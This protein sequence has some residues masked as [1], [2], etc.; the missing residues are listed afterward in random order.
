MT[1][2][3]SKPLGEQAWERYE[4]DMHSTSSPWLSE[5][6]YQTYL[7]LETLPSRFPSTKTTWLR[8]PLLHDY[9]WRVSYWHDKQHRLSCDLF[10]PLEEASSP[11]SSSSS[12]FFSSLSAQT[13]AAR[14]DDDNEDND[15]EDGDGAGT[16]FAFNLDWLDRT[17]QRQL[18][19]H[20]S[21]TNGGLHVIVELV[22]RVSGIPLSR[23]SIKIGPQYSGADTKNISIGVSGAISLEMSSCYDLRFVTSTIPNRIGFHP[24]ILNEHLP[25]YNCV[26][27]YIRAPSSASHWKMNRPLVILPAFVPSPREVILAT[28]ADS[29]PDHLLRPCR[30]FAQVEDLQIT[31]DLFDLCISD[32][33]IVSARCVGG[34]TSHAPTPAFLGEMVT[35]GE[36]SWLTC[37]EVQLPHGATT[38]SKIRLDIVG[39]SIGPETET[40]GKGS[41]HHQKAMELCSGVLTPKCKRNQSSPTSIYDPSQ[42][43]HE[44][45]KSSSSSG[46]GGGYLSEELLMAGEM[47]LESGVYEVPLFAHPTTVVVGYRSMDEEGA[48]E[49]PEG[50]FVGRLVV[51]LSVIGDG[52]EGPI[53]HDATDLD[54]YLFP[55]VFNFDIVGV[56]LYS[57]PVPQC[58]A[59]SICDHL[60]SHLLSLDP[61]PT[62]MVHPDLGDDLGRRNV[63]DKLGVVDAISCVTACSRRI[64]SQSSGLSRTLLSPGA[65]VQPHLTFAGGV[66]QRDSNSVPLLVMSHLVHRLLQSG[67]CDAPVLS[68]IA[69][70]IDKAGGNNG[71]WSTFQAWSSSTSA[72]QFMSG[73]H[74]A[75]K[76]GAS[77]QFLIPSKD[78]FDRA[79][80]AFWCFRVLGF[81]HHVERIHG[82]PLLGPTSGA[83]SSSSLTT[84]ASMA[85]DLLHVMLGSLAPTI[86]HLVSE[87][88]VS[89]AHAKAHASDAELVNAELEKQRALCVVTVAE[90]LSSTLDCSSLLLP[91]AGDI[92]FNVASSVLAVTE[93][94]VKVPFTPLCGGAASPAAS[95][96]LARFVVFISLLIRQ[97]PSGLDLLLHPTAHV[98]TRSAVGKMSSQ[99]L[100]SERKVVTGTAA[101]RASKN[102]PGR[103]GGGGKS[104]DNS[105]AGCITD[106]I[107]ALCTFFSTGG[108]EPFREV[109]GRISG[110]ITIA[111]RELSTTI[112]RAVFARIVANPASSLS[113]SAS[114]HGGA[115]A[116]E[117]TSPLP[118]LPATA[119][120]KKGGAALTSVA[121]GS[122]SNSASSANRIST[123]ADIKELYSQHQAY[124]AK[125]VYGNV[126][127]L[128]K[129][130]PLGMRSPAVG[131]SSV[132]A[133]GRERS[134]AYHEEK[135]DP[136]TVTA[137]RSLMENGGM[138]VE[139]RNGTFTLKGD[140]A[141]IYIGERVQFLHGLLVLAVA[142]GSL[143]EI[144]CDARLGDGGAMSATRARS[145]VNVVLNS[146]VPTPAGFANE[147]HHDELLKQAL[148][149]LAQSKGPSGSNYVLLLIHLTDAFALYWRS[150][151]ALTKGM[152]SIEPFTIAAPHVVIPRLQSLDRA[153]LPIQL[154]RDVELLTQAARTLFS[155][156]PNDEALSISEVRAYS[157]A[158][159]FRALAMQQQERKG[160]LNESFLLSTGD[161][162]GISS[163]LRLRRNLI[164]AVVGLLRAGIRLG[165]FEAEAVLAH[166]ANEA[167][168]KLNSASG[169]PS[170][171]HPATHDS[172]VRRLQALSSLADVS[173]RTPTRAVSAS[174]FAGTPL[175]CLVWLL[176]D[177]ADM[178]PLEENRTDLALLCLQSNDDAKRTLTTLFSIAVD[179]PVIPADSKLPAAGAISKVLDMARQDLMGGCINVMQIMSYDLHAS[180]LALEAYFQSILD[181]CIAH[182]IPAG[183]KETF[184]PVLSALL[185]SS[186]TI[187]PTLVNST[188][189]GFAAA[190]SSLLNLLSEPA[191]M[192]ST[193]LWKMRERITRRLTA[194]R[195]FVLSRFTAALPEPPAGSDE[196]IEVA[197]RKSFSLVAAGASLQTLLHM[198]PHQV[199]KGGWGL[200]LRDRG[201]VLKELGALTPSNGSRTWSLKDDPTLLEGHHH[202][203]SHPL[204][205]QMGRGFSEEQL[206][207][208]LRNLGLGHRA[209]QA[210]MHLSMSEVFALEQLVA[211]A[212][213]AGGDGKVSFIDVEYGEDEHR[214]ARAALTYMLQSGEWETGLSLAMT[215][216]EQCARTQAK[217][218]EALQ[219]AT[220]KVTQ[221][222][223]AANNSAGQVLHELTLRI[224]RQNTLQ[225]ELSKAQEKLKQRLV[226]DEQHRPLPIFYALR[227][228]ENPWIDVDV[229]HG[230]EAFLDATNCH[231]QGFTVVKAV[232][233]DIDDLA[234]GREERKKHHRHLDTDSNDDDGKEL[235]RQLKKKKEEAKEAAAPPGIGRGMWILLRC[236]PT[237]FSRNA[238]V[239][240]ELAE[241]AT[242]KLRKRRAYRGSASS[243]SCSEDSASSS[244]SSE[245]EDD[246]D[247]DDEDESNRVK[248]PLPSACSVSLQAQLLR[249]FPSYQML[250]PISLV[251]LDQMGDET[252][253]RAMQLFQAFPSAL[254]AAADAGLGSSETVGVHAVLRKQTEETAASSNTS[255]GDEGDEYE[256]SKA[257]KANDALKRGVSQPESDWEMA[258]HSDTFYVF[259]SLDNESE[260][261][262]YLSSH[263][264]TSIVRLT[265][266]TVSA[267]SGAEAAKGH[268]VDE[269]GEHKGE[270][271]ADDVDTSDMGL[272]AWAGDRAGTIGKLHVLAPASLLFVTDAKR[273][274]AFEAGMSVIRHQL[275]ALNRLQSALSNASKLT[276]TETLQQTSHDITSN[277]SVMAAVANTVSNMI[278]SPSSICVGVHNARA[279]VSFQTLSPHFPQI[280]H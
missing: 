107:I 48:D 22:H 151:T 163:W 169:D 186:D 59:T 32:R 158:Q 165:L 45:G 103:R 115:D 138:A 198:A 29:G 73:A 102:A 276:M 177:L 243:D 247:D 206:F 172:F 197:L 201:V 205:S 130:V 157:S 12:S 28:N 128:G 52:G 168:N 246:E 49:E 23:G 11:A 16:V 223:K 145:I 50:I 125:D 88:Y 263:G 83:Y 37:S 272:L 67:V 24:T 26:L 139:F 143:S 180:P 213:A 234:G 185:K 269:A 75:K 251:E 179:L 113:A 235:E 153:Y 212:G 144:P 190:V 121:A 237:A 62:W 55:K 97:Q 60:I 105:A 191:A 202:N 209:G 44:E 236:D 38:L 110:S 136:V 219:V 225:T 76:K 98:W 256:T 31:P 278:V 258:M 218:Q 132:V 167:R 146:I 244:S 161:L 187:E 34:G 35:N 25:E 131:L 134:G 15:E 204:L 150:C 264:D 268:E 56:G 79:K 99:S 100:K 1:K 195:I 123:K 230:L 245:D 152:G 94:L 70:L 81:S 77:L 137:V 120:R 253:P 176:R 114:T 17:Q 200:D 275:Q 260:M 229:Q 65:V 124:S 71:L 173:S 109:G 43:G 47:V 224:R 78:D 68:T 41:N 2:S 232:S 216:S 181:E 5:D 248:V 196:Y 54:P 210:L 63:Y 119:R 271:D 86:N 154:A 222:S 162:S 240:Q 239:Y 262:E 166:T 101:D 84:T 182:C 126:T 30:C 164:D 149:S 61:L 160:G 140:D 257:F 188:P 66:S 183:M 6:G 20:A 72:Q 112:E 175:N 184:E 90:I 133:N 148:D 242:E 170:Q 226:H 4:I 21:S 95:E 89:V 238:E 221:A 274:T 277:A 194:V 270:Q 14:D 93:A 106:C 241:K 135:H 69:S 80:V 64:S 207:D 116:V 231:L 259:A 227:F 273:F 40:G 215:L 108:A 261:S 36:G 127:F 111:L 250:P 51:F 280:P 265:L 214:R 104:A 7:L 220:A 91:V 156:V 141:V 254:C 233:S 87:Y 211:G 199:G 33:V 96:S 39:V 82:L 203:L 18:N 266:S 217:I 10:L 255:G 8:G 92:V 19:Y 3:S 252:H 171:P 155:R 13:T 46:G 228:L 9:R 53:S 279:L 178:E 27:S 192:S 129:K 117:P 249:A 85:G 193:A 208:P 267:L 57:H 142:V 174:S 58:V 147:A 122:S 159:R 42:Q 74:K 189:A 118:S